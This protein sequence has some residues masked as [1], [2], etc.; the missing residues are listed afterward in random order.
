MV[1]VT[2]IRPFWDR[3]ARRDRRAGEVFEATEGRASQIAA[4]LPGYVTWGTEAEL[5]ADETSDEPGLDSMT[6]AQ[7]RALAAER[8]IELP[9]GAKKAQIIE[10]IRG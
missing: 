3:M 9:K 5:V 1:S 8:G 10:T 2:V 4:T 6:V 7:L